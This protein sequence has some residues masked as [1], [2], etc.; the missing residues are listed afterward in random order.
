MTLRI[1]VTGSS[2]LIGRTI[3]R[4]LRTEGMEVAELDLRADAPQSR[5]D[6]CDRDRLAQALQG[7][8]GIIHL[9]AV[10]R[11]IDGERD[12]ARC[13]RV[14]A[15]A[16]GDVL[17][18]A[19]AAMPRPWVI[20]ASSREVY[21]Q[22]D[23]L[24]V[25]EHAPLRPKN[26]YARSKAEAERLVGEGRRAGLQTAILRFSNVY[27]DTRDH[28]D[29]VVPAFARAAALAGQATSEVRVDGSDCTFDF[30]Y[31]ADVAD[32]I[33]RVVRLLRDGETALPPIHF[34]TG[35]QTSLGQLA[36]LARS[37]GG[38]SLGI[39]DAPPRTFDV[40]RFAGDPTLAERLLGWRA[41]T[42]LAAGFRALANAYREELAPVV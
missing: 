5:G 6:L 28:A 14:N 26:I 2:G 20:Y 18:L 12:P 17:R 7:V 38:P 29:R 8:A 36:L 22:Q 21:G 23:A 37:V 15:E 39:V 1:L 33:L 4:R 9:A 10:S 27:G 42:Q 24:P 11:V 19:A 40:H 32:G 34:V 3:T 30:T 13:W 31:V 16:T 41:T 35:T 25:P